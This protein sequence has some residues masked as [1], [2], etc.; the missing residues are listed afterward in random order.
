M[1]VVMARSATA[2]DVQRVATAIEEMGYRA[3]PMASAGRTVVGIIGNDRP[4][5]GSRL[6]AMPGVSELVP[7]TRP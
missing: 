2:A 3:R 6:A 1:L 7:I 5:D 4:V